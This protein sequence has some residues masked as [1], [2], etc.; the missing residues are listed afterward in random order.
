MRGLPIFMHDSLIAASLR[1]AIATIPNGT[2]VYLVGGAVRNAIYYD[3]FHR[4]LPQRDFDLV[5]SGDLHGMVTNMRQRGFIYG[6]IRRKHQIVM[7]RKR[8]PHATTNAAFV[9]LDLHRTTGTARKNLK[10]NATFTINGFALPLTAVT[11]SAWRQKII[12]LPSARND[13]RRKQLRLNVIAHPANLYAC[14]RFMSLGFTP[15][16]K[17][18]ID[19]LLAAL[20][21]LETWRFRRNVEKVYEYVGGRQNA[22][23]LTRRLGIHF[24]IF[25]L[26]ELR[27]WRS[28]RQP[29]DI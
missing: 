11:S 18:D 3:M 12:A 28:Q 4:Q 1:D 2:R 21:R 17:R 26:K 19:A 9:A 29:Q 6:R 25:D 8:M 5:V 23:R 24:D 22:L 14:L 7:K 10:E 27:K 13:L 15:P 20:T 16:P